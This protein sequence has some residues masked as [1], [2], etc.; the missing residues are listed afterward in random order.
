MQ[1]KRVNMELDNGTN[2]SKRYFLADSGY[3]SR[4]IKETIIKRGFNPLILQNKR[5]IKDKTKIIKFTKA[6]GKMYAKRLA[7]ER[8][9]NRMKMDRRVSIRYDC[10]IDAYMGFVY[11]SLIKLLF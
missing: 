3:D 2:V 9:F 1:L 7:I 8:T 4:V 5:G 10:K 6:E 11:L